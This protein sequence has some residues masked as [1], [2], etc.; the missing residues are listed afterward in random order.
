MDWQS[1]R[2]AIGL[3]VNSSMS[4][5]FGCPTNSEQHKHT[6]ALI[7]LNLPWTERQIQISSQLNLEWVGPNCSNV[8]QSR[9][10]GLII[11]TSASSAS[12][13]VDGP[14][15]F[16]L[17]RFTDCGCADLWRGIALK[18]APCKV[19]QRH[20]QQHSLC[21]QL[22]WTLTLKYRLQQ[23]PGAA[24]VIIVVE[25]RALFRSVKHRR[26]RQRRTSFAD[27]Q[28]ESA[29]QSALEDEE[30]AAVDVAVEVTGTV[31]V[32]REELEQDQ[33]HSVQHP[34]AH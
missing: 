23:L 6:F 33:L 17:R 20:S 15:F 12:S 30:P 18:E 22:I 32:E 4:T 34:P 2:T 1:Q 5:R 31:F 21:H 8:L 25:E 27:Q 16:L 10:S 9:V 28:W 29:V 26:S 11:L 3:V 7:A 13:F 24:N 14:P 19:S